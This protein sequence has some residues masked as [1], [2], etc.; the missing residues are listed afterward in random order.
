MEPCP[1]CDLSANPT[2]TAPPS[3]EQC[4]ELLSHQCKSFEKGTDLMAALSLA[5]RCALS[6]VRQARIPAMG[7]GAVVFNRKFVPCFYNII[8][9][10]A[11]VQDG[12]FR[13]EKLPPNCLFS[14]VSAARTA[15]RLAASRTS[16]GDSSIRFAPTGPRGWKSS[17]F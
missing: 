5:Q 3:D 1:R 12:H 10:A 17:A 7:N 15:P 4:D 8:A 14:V 13:F 9:A 11:A 16:G 6:Q 2:P